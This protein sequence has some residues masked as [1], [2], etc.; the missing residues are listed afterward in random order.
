MT[1][2]H[3]LSHDMSRAM[4]PRALDISRKCNSYPT[5][6]KYK[7]LHYAN[8]FY[9][10]CT[11]FNLTLII[12]LITTSCGIIRGNTVKGILE[13]HIIFT[14]VRSVQQTGP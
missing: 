12:D 10:S 4:N 6:T 9:K 1:W 14:G 7:A 11:T 3:G 5:R 2:S 13:H 8:I